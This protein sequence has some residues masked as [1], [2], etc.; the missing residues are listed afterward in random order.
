MHRVNRLVFALNN[1]ELLLFGKYAPSRHIDHK[2][3]TVCQCC[4]KRFRAEVTRIFLIPIRRVHGGPT[5]LQADQ[6]Q[7]LHLSLMDDGK[8]LVLDIGS[9][10]TDLIKNN[11]P[12]PP[13]GCWCFDI[14]QSTVCT[15][16]RESDQVVKIQKT[17]VVVPKT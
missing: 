4:V 14:L 9:A 3:K 7:A 15:W 5:V 6:W 12:C 1:R 10:A 2:G 11:S 16:Q 17:C 8:E 13:N